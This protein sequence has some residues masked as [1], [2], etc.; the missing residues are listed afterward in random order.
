[1]QA[2]SESAINED[3]LPTLSIEAAP[4]PQV[5]E[6]EHRD[7]AGR[8]SR[9]DGTTLER[10]DTDLADVLAFE[11]G[12]Q[13][14]RVGGFGSFSSLSVRAS[15]ASQTSIFLDGI[16][17]N[18]AAN[19]VVDLSAFDLR[20]LNSVDIYRGAAPL[21]LGSTN[22][23]GAVNLNSAQL[24]NDFTQI[25][26]TAG[27]FGTLQTNLSHQQSGS[28]WNTVATV[29]A[30]RS[31]ND[32]ELLNNNTT[33]L[34]PND[35]VRE[36]RNNA[37]VRSV[38]VLAK[39]SYAFTDQISNDVLIQH[40]QRTTGVPEFRNID[41]NQASFDEGRG[42]LHLSY[43]DK[44]F[45]GWAQKHTVFTQ[46]VNDRYDDRFSQV[47]LG[48]QN[49]RSQQRVL[50]ASTYWDQFIFGGK[51]ALTAEVRREEFESEDPLNRGPEREIEASRNSIT[52]G[53]A[54]TRFAFDDNLIITPRLRLENHNSDRSGN[55]LTSLSDDGDVTVN[56]ELSTRWQQNESLAWTASVGRYF[57]IPTFSEQFGNQGLVTG[58]EELNPEEGINTELGVQWSPYESLNLS[59][60]AFYSSRDDTIVT[61][62]DA[63]GI[64]RNLNTGAA[65]IQGLELE[66]TW[67]PTKRLNIKTNLTLQD[68][69]NQSDILAFS[70]KQLPNQSAITAYARGDF[71]INSRLKIWSELSVS[72]DRFFDLGN[73]LPAEDAAVVS[74]GSQ[75]RRNN[76][77]ADFTIS[78]LTDE[79]IEDFNG[80]DN[81]I[82]Q[83]IIVIIA[84]A[85]T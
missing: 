46:W 77:S 28:N 61:V 47:G 57:R 48:A 40:T 60:T 81:L 10:T 19:S 36:A 4:E 85:G 37:D 1:V 70:G 14:Q 82:S 21:L 15:T 33:P 6:V 11:T 65:T 67:L 62:F 9:I 39:A 8:F 24:A 66:S 58:N 5:G 64:G 23:G 79:T 52:G 34:N 45:D 56:P 20:S 51:W 2:Q 71:Q 55:S 69:T 80:F 3:V 72:Q 43:R 63:R 84:G 35:D 26:F 22:L 27:S 29:Q 25:K 54:Y 74:L 17:L 83:S 76:L 68:T 78:N 75:W 38:G 16:R 12:I 32:F 50:G 44:N 18:G 42:Q 73:F 49:F 59:A 31:D 7:F 41:N 30:S 13:Q 53:F